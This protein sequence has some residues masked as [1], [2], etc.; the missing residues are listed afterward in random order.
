[1]KCV[2]KF[3]TE[4]SRHYAWACLPVAETHSLFLTF[5][6]RLHVSVCFLSFYWYSCRLSIPPFSSFSFFLYL[7]TFL[8][9]TFS[10][11]LHI[12]SPYLMNS[13]SFLLFYFYLLL[14]SV[15]FISSFIYFF[16]YFF[17]YSIFIAPQ[18]FLFNFSLLFILYFCLY[19]LFGL[20]SVSY[21]FHIYLSSG[22]P[23]LPT[24]HSFF[25]F[26]YLIFTFL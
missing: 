10:S 7:F 20:V 14:S 16:I 6:L 23:F 11:F 8:S 25:V 15:S 3:C 24:F 5:F 22:V 21:F 26:V 2:N 12:L 1:M 19:S 18:S 9:S 4:R 17:L 13:F